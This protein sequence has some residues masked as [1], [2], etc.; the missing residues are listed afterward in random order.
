MTYNLSELEEKYNVK[1]DDTQLTV[2]SSLI[3]FIYDKSSNRITLCG[4]PGT[5][6][7][8][9][10]KILYEILVDNGYYCC[11][12]VPT[13]KAKSLF[14]NGEYI[15][16]IHSLLNLQPNFNILEFDASKLQFDLFKSNIKEL[17]SYD[18][19]I[20]DECSM[21]NTSLYNTLINRYVSGKIIFSGDPKQLA[22]IEDNQI[23]K[24]FDNPKIYLNVI[25]RQSEGIVQK[26]INYLRN[27]SIQQFKTVSDDYSSITVYNDINVMLDTY[28]YL[29]KLLGDFQ[30]I[31]LAKLVTYSNNRITA[32]NKIIRNKLY[33]DSEEYHKREI[34]TAYDTYRVDNAIVLE[35]SAD[36]FI[37][38]FQKCIINNKYPGY[39]LT[40]IDYNNCKITFKIISR[41]TPQWMLDEL[42]ENLENLR[43]KACKSKSKKDW[44]NYFN[45]YESFATP[46]DLVYDNRIIKRKT[47]DYGYCI[48]VYKSQGSGYQIVMIDMENISRY[49]KGEKLRQL[50][51]VACSRT[52]S[53]LIIYQKDI[54]SLIKNQ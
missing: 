34:L 46:I 14:T 25:Y 2:L 20:V 12:I 50:Q 42:A 19:L 30:S 40:V 47:L 37:V 53:D 32:L 9:I 38:D 54:H 5:G 22:C 49:A 8:L 11:C 1:L 51:Y 15:Q 43:V 26:T 35:N 23:S 13:N 39:K 10:L 41:E 3:N 36:Y 48:S 6:K 18:I 28:G 17:N 44:I 33:N 29:F 31:N 4:Y 52:T 27:K 45:L 21:I 24:T 16:T 7:T